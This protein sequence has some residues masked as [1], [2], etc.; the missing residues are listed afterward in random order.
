MVADV[1][2]DVA[3]G[4]T[5][6][7]FFGIFVVKIN[8]ISFNKTVDICV[9]G[10]LNLSNGIHVD[11]LI[12]DANAADIL[13]GAFVVINHEVGVSVEDVDAAESS[14]RR[15]CRLF[16]RSFVLLRRRLQLLV[17][18]HAQRL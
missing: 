4:R 9:V 17:L 5:V 11:V 3:F 6:D 12:I 14:L 18:P 2:L 10:V 7:V 13:I 15:R 1:C 8:D 16:L